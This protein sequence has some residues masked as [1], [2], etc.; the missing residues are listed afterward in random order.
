MSVKVLIDSAVASGH[1]TTADYEKY[2][3]TYQFSFNVCIY[4]KRISASNN[5]F[6]L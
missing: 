5:F 2:I 1:N 6:P 3:L 4:L